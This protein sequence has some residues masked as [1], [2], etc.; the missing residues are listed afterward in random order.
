MQIVKL[1]KIDQSVLL[2]SSVAEST[3]PEYNSGT[4]YTTGDVVKVSYESDGITPLAPVREYESLADS[5]TGNYPPDS[6]AEWIEIG[7]TNRWAMFDRFVNT[8]T[9]DTEAIE[10]EL[11]ASDQTAVGLFAMQAQEVTLTLIVD[12]QLLTDGDGATD[13]FDKGDGWSYDS[14]NQ[15]YDCDGTQAA[16]SLLTQSVTV[17]P[18]LY[19][20]VQ[21]TVANYSAGNVA[22]YV[23]GAS[24]SNVAANGTYSQI[25]FPADSSGLVGVVADP[26]FVGSITNVSVKK[27][28]KHETISLEYYDI[29]VVVGWYYYFFSK[30]D[31]LEDLFW[32]FNNYSAAI[33]RIKIRWKPGENAKCGMCAMGVR[34]ELGKTE[35]EPSV[36]IIDY[37]KKDTDSLGRTYL[38]QGAF[39]KRA[40]ISLW[41]YN[42]RIDAV[43]R[44]LQSARGEPIVFNANNAGVAGTDFTSLLIYGFYRDFDITIAGPTISR[45]NFDIEG[46]I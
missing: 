28:H 1:T 21:F 29:S 2:S 38:A 34:Y 7:S 42:S 11:D 3:K 16:E 13:S 20:E 37:S 26:D 6:P 27:V 10:I 4:T 43:R 14:G 18:M 40:D 41:L 9:A 22:G 36:G 32:E 44:A 8:Q 33:L 25:I 39:A 35:Y 17:K 45:C 23:A 15:E 5:N 12:Q 19:Y 24:G 31:Y 46:L 30:L